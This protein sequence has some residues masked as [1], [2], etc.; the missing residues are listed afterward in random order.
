MNDGPVFSD[1]CGKVAEQRDRTQVLRISLNC[2]G[3]AQWDRLQPVG[4]CDP[5]KSTY[6]A[7][8]AP[9]AIRAFKFEISNL[10][11]QMEMNQGQFDE[12]IMPGARSFLI[13]APP[14][15]TNFTRCISVMSSSGFPETAIMS[16]NLPFSTLPRLSAM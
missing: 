3:H 14:F 2:N 6:P 13:T 12:A 9:A 4:L 5:Q 7:R 11:Y 1:L 16:A 15:I 10:R 8:I